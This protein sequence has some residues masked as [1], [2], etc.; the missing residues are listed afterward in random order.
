MFQRKKIEV[1]TKLCE[2]VNH[3]NCTNQM[4]LDP[5]RDFYALW[6]SGRCYSMNEDNDDDEIP[7]TL[8]A[9]GSNQ[10]AH[11]KSNARLTRPMRSIANALGGNHCSLYWLKS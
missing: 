9:P 4:Y 6:L 5:K 2:L 10:M 11:R 8:G 7:A 3:F 1:N